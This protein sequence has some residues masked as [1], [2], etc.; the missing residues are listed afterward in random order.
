MHY[1]VETDLQ[2]AVGVSEFN[3]KPKETYQYK[4]DVTPVLG[5]T[6]TASIT[7]IDDDGRFLWWTVEVRTESPTPQS[8]ITMRACVRKATTAIVKLANPLKIPITFEVHY[9]GEGLIGD[10]T[11]TLDPHSES[12]Y[13]L[14]FSPLMA[15]NFS[16]TIGFLNRD[17]GE[18]WYELDLIA[19]ENPVVRLDLLE[20]E[21]GRTESHFV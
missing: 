11:L 17:V 2:R 21:L 10:P 20:C 1:R 5:G 6:Y 4:L 15:G 12:A 7:F 18:F 9:S 8:T 16:G 13:N 3:V 19:E 14:V